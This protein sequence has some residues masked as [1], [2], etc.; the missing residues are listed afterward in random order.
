MFRLI[1]ILTVICLATTSCHHSASV[2][3][4]LATAESAMAEGSYQTVQDICDEITADTDIE[5]L[6]V[7]TRCRLAL[8]YM[9]LAEQRNEPENTAT[10]LKCYRTALTDAPDSTSQAFAGLPVEDMQYAMILST[11]SSYADNDSL[12]IHDHESDSLY[13]DSFATGI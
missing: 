9:K 10:A 8:L 6:P 3:D 12:I 7:N 5:N 13:I 11:L 4:S 2:A 1:S